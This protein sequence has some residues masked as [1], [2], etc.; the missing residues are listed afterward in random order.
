MS[1]ITAPELVTIILGIVG[2][3]L[4]L[5]YRYAPKL[6]DWYQSRPNKG[7]WALGLDAIVGAAYYGLSCT[8]YAAQWKIALS[9]TQD[10]LFVLINAIYIIALTQQLTFVI[11]PKKLLTP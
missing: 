2:V 4:Q 9:C 1:N 7:L 11:L 8:S 10:G 6:S 5:L 3:V